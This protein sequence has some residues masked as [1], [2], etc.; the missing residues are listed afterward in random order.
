MMTY[1]AG[2]GCAGSAR[3]RGRHADHRQAAGGLRRAGRER[4]GVQGARFASSSLL[5]VDSATHQACALCLALHKGFL[6]VLD[7]PKELLGAAVHDSVN[8]GFT[9]S[10]LSAATFMECN[11]ILA[12]VVGFPGVPGP[13]EGVSWRS[14]PRPGRQGRGGQ[15]AHRR[16][17]GRRAPH[18]WLPGPGC[19]ALRRGRRA[20]RR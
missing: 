10:T 11:D 12:A 8:K 18:L 9:P 3:A 7:L 6:A 13:A 16:Q 17:P 5:L 20:R 19:H 1:M 14:H 4:H 15:G 2:L